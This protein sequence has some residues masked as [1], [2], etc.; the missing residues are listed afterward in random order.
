MNTLNSRRAAAVSAQNRR[1]FIGTMVLFVVVAVICT[2]AFPVKKEQTTQT[3]T[4][5]QTQAQAQ[6][7]FSLDEKEAAR[8]A[9]METH[10]LSVFNGILETNPDMNIEDITTLSYN[11]VNA[12]EE[13]NVSPFLLAAIV[14]TESGF[15]N[16]APNEVSAKGYAQV[17]NICRTEAARHGYSFNEATEIDN[18]RCSAWYLSYLTDT[19]GDNEDSIIAGYNAGVSA[20]VEA[21]GVPDYPETREYVKRVKAARAR[22]ASL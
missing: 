12:A 3:Q 21:G 20:I 10:R 2:I 11:V 13:F 15:H 16:L 22:I 14:K 18:L 17:T 6:D 1:Y 19:F 5:T 9:R 7:F 4:Q 8:A